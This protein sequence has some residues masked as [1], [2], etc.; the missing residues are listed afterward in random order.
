MI[1]IPKPG[2]G[3]EGS[4]LWAETF[5]SFFIAY[6]FMAMAVDKN[7]KVIRSAMAPALALVFFLNSITLGEISGGGFNPSRSLAPALI[8]GQIGS[9]QFV[10]FIGPIIGSVMA[11]IIYNSVFV[12]DMIDKMEHRRLER[13]AQEDEQSENIEMIERHS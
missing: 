10:H 13:L 3:Y 5:G 1:G 4:E 6:V 11:A 2:G 12:D 7:K 9:L 8:V